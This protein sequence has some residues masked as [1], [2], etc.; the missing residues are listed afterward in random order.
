MVFSMYCLGYK[1]WENNENWLS[2]FP[3]VQGNLFTWLTKLQFLTSEKLERANDQHLINLNDKSII[4]SWHFIFCPSA[5][6]LINHEGLIV[7]NERGKWRYSI[8]ELPLKKDKTL[9]YLHEQILCKR[10]SENRF[11]VMMNRDTDRGG[12]ACLHVSLLVSMHEHTQMCPS[13]PEQVV[14]MTMLFWK[15]HTLSFASQTIRSVSCSACHHLPVMFGS[16]STFLHHC[17]C[18]PPPPPYTPSLFFH[19]LLCVS[20]PNTS[21]SSHLSVTAAV[22]CFWSS[23]RLLSG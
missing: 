22:P 12:D 16:S 8:A 20:V 9:I 15:Q 19:V 5:T 1:I 11:P 13:H 14:I 18:P 3:T 6:Q 21:H 10:R 4:N 7:S 2:Q 17:P 23:R